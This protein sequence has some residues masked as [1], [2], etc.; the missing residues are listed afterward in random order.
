MKTSYYLKN[1]IFTIL[2][3]VGV[4]SHGQ[5]HSQHQM[6]K[7]D[8]KAAPFSEDSIYNLKSSLLDSEGKK[9]T[10]EELRGQPVVISMAYTSCAYACPL[11]ISHMQRLEKAL[12][13]QGKKNVRFVLVSFDPKKDKPEV[14]KRYSEKRKLSAQWKFYTSSSDKAPREIANLLGIK[15]KR[16]DDT[17]FD[18]SFI[19]SVL[20]AEGVIQGQ[21]SGAD[22]NPEDLAKFIQ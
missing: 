20:N 12:L 10:L 7:A 3:L 16:I 2:F 11:I 1:V 21:L 17:D 6:P 22:K 18:H 4:S 9:A 5:D 15:Y 8:T 13:S 19:I 14:I